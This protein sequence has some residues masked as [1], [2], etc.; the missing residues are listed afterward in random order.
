MTYDSIGRLISVTDAK[1]KTTYYYYDQMDR[2]IEVKDTLD[3][4]TRYTYDKK[5]NLLVITD[6]KNQTIKYE[7]DER[8]RLKK[9]TDQLGR[10]ETYE[11][12][13]SDNLVK[14]TDRK[15]QITNYSYDLMNRVTNATYADGSYTTYIYDVV[16]RPTTITDSISGTISYTYS[17]SGCTTGC[18]TV[19]RITQEVTPLGT[20]DYTYDQVGRRITM[21]V[22]GQPVVNYVYDDAGRLTNV[23][24]MVGT[25][26]RNFKI[27]YDNG[28]RRTQLEYLKGSST[29]P[30]T[31][32]TYSHDIAN[33]L[34]NLKHLR[35]STTLENLLYEYD[36]NGNR[37]KFTRNAIQPFRNGATGITYNEANQMLTFTPSGGSTK[38]ITY[39]ENGNL[40]TVTNNCGTTTYSWDARNRLVG[41]NGFK[42]D[43]SALT[44]SFKYDALGRRYE[45]TI[46]GV[47]TQYV[48]D[49][50]DIIQEKQNGAVYANYI[51]TLN[52]D[53]PLARIKGSVIRH[54]KTDALGSVINLTDDSGYVKTTYTY[55]PFG[56]VTVSGESSDNP[57]QY[58]GRENDGTGLYYYR[59]RY[60]S[61]ELQRFINEDPI[62]LAG[63]KHFYIPI[64]LYQYV[65]NDPIN[66]IDPY[67]LQITRG[68]SKGILSGGT[69]ALVGGT[70]GAGIGAGLGT[71]TGI[72]GMGIVG[73]FALGWAGGKIGGLFDPP[74]A[75]QLNCNEPMPPQPPQPAK[76]H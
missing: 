29:T 76:C 9:M 68:I 10:F 30:T 36:P 53:E 75:G 74:C 70:I 38:N 12:D 45:K 42:T 33:R 47:T 4:I 32:T 51:R 63:G 40:L 21:T 57:F 11:Y 62:K 22:A 43:C 28:S 50:L 8:D 2:I 24:R 27:T 67:G 17:D 54:Y 46:N 5:G 71:A 34:L 61:P 55:D 16:G 72:P 15:G 7:Y 69:G 66:W 23:K 39:D 73:G 19:D 64:N 41:I 20:I 13:T 60:Y 65:G 56:N 14:F 49:G 48:Y 3:G 59:A 1:G 18:G 25:T 37:T 44:A 6:A 52:I 58:T 26:N 31:K 35:S